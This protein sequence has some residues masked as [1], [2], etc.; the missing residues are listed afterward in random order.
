MLLFHGSQKQIDGK[1]AWSSMQSVLNS[2]AMFECGTPMYAW[3]PL[4]THW[5]TP[6]SSTPVQPT[7]MRVPVGQPSV[8]EDLLDAL[9]ELALVRAVVVDLGAVLHARLLRLVAR[10]EAD[11]LVEPVVPQVDAVADEALVHALPYDRS[12]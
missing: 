2:K 12:R 4:V 10:H 3:L 8:A 7:P 1:S 9:R 11:V 5:S 6:L